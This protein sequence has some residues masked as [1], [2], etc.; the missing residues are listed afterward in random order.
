MAIQSGM[1]ELIINGD[2]VENIKVFSQIDID[3]T[4]FELKKSYML[5]DLKP[6]YEYE[7]WLVYK[8]SKK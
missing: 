4:I 3:K 1:L 2:R 6:I 8:S 5:N 7:F